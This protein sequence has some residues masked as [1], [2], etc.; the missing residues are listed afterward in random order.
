M[1]E[2]I[3]PVMNRRAFIDFAPRFGCL[4]TLRFLDSVARIGNFFSRRI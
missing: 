3:V 1:S 2:D 4:S